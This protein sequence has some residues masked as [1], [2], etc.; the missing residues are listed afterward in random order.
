MS[1]VTLAQSIQIF[2][3]LQ[4]RWEVRPNA[5]QFCCEAAMIGD[6]LILIGGQDTSTLEITDKVST[7][8]EDHEDPEGCWSNKYPPLPDRLFRPGT[9]YHNGIL[10]VA[11]GF[12]GADHTLS[13]S[14]HVLATRESDGILHLSEREHLHWY[15]IPGLC[16]PYAAHCFSVCSTQDH[17]V[18]INHYQDQFFISK[19]VIRC[20]WADFHRVVSG[21]IPQLC[22]SINETTD[23]LY[24][25]ISRPLWAELSD[26]P[27]YRSSFV[28][29]GSSVIALGGT[30]DGHR[31]LQKIY[32]LDV[33]QASPLWNYA[34]MLNSDEILKPNC[35]AVGLTP[36]S[37][38]VI[39]GCSNPNSWRTSMC[40]KVFLVH[41]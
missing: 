19:G 8:V 11:G 12:S 15:T 30:D 14:V 28:S 20:K 35:S 6:Q 4:N 1:E 26:I 5:P 7:L 2:D 9:A 23:D 10:V 16:L 18:L 31:H 33:S 37:F 24:T 32:L 29:C 27:L 40:N 21:T 36:T 34:R 3:T 38:L 41:M 22:G 17:L 39:G 25:Q 13:D